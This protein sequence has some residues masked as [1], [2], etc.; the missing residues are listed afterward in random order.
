M[1]ENS[2]L[3][4]SKQTIFLNV[5]SKREFHTNPNQNLLKMPMKIPMINEQHLWELYIEVLTIW[6]ASAQGARIISFY[7]LLGNNFSCDIQ[8]SCTFL[9]VFVTPLF[10]QLSLICLT[11]IA[12]K[13]SCHKEGEWEA[14]SRNQPKWY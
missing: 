4:L 7:D 8:V 1:F 12:T 13:N 2:L 5:R 10:F 11:G 3:E 6:Y 14:C 9:Y